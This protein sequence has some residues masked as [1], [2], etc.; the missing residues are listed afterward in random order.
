MHHIHRVLSQALKQ[1]VR[2]RMLLRNPCE[3]IDAPKIERREMKVWDIAT[4]ATALELV[5]PWRVHIPVVLAVLCGLRRG[6]IA[7]SS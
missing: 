2:W 4:A 5:R 6:E 3:D 7:A 1:A